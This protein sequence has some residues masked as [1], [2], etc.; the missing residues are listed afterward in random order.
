MSSEESLCKK[1]KVVIIYMLMVI[2]T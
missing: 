2:Y 1:D